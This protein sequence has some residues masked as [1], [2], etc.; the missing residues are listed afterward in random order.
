MMAHTSLSIFEIIELKLKGYIHFCCMSLGCFS[1]GLLSFR[2]LIEL[3]F[4]V[5]KSS[6]LDHN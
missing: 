4:F 6:C 3:V 5:K 1:L 2:I